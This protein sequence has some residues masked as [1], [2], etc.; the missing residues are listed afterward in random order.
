MI[1]MSGAWFFVVAS[2]AISVG[3]DH[4][5][6][7]RRRL[8]RG[9]WPSPSTTCAA[10]GWAV[11][12]MLLVILLYDQLLFRPLVAWAEK[13]RIDPA[14]RR[15]RRRRAPGC[16]TSSSAPSWPAA[17]GAR[18]AAFLSSAGQRPA[19][20]THGVTPR[21]S[22]QVWVEPG[23]WTSPGTALL[24]LVAAC[25]PPGAPSV[26]I[27]AA[28]QRGEVGHGLRPGLPHPAARGGADRAGQRRLGA[29][30]GVDRACGR[31][32][33]RALQ[34][35]TQF[36]AAFPANLLFPVAVAGIVRFDLTPDIWLSPLMILGAQWYI[37]FNVIAGARA[38][39]A[40]LLEVAAALRL[41]GWA[42]WRKV[43]LPG[44]F[45]SYVTGAI[46]A[47]GRRLE[48]GHRRRGGE[49]GRH[50]PV[51]PRPRRLYRR[52]HRGG[53]PA[54]GGA[55]GGGDGGLCGPVQPAGL[56]P[57]VHRRR[58]PASADAEQIRCPPPSAAR[59]PRPSPRP[60]C[61]WRSRTCA[62][63]TPRPPPTTSWCWTAST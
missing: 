33:P 41:K 12:T 20:P 62:R 61:C 48:R 1:S 57:L 36:L 52:R 2:E 17:P 7:A 3:R 10:V 34:P 16:W 53:R 58:P 45:P 5:L 40:D 18:S 29:D 55:G 60:R 44:I 50:A 21:R 19:R 26:Y 11:L 54:P 28:D 31:A 39:P 4:R 32:G 15:T 59:R 42:W 14:A 35:V 25:S 23:R 27:G 63:P 8:L 30:R 51:G 22:P 43:A 13:F 49:L 6:P 37:L 9:A 56:G 47:G 38:F 24:G 46:T